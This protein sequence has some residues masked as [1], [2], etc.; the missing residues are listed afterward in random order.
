M[1]EQKRKAKSCHSRILGRAWKSQWDRKDE[2][3]GSNPSSESIMCS[4]NNKEDLKSVN[5]NSNTEYTKR[6]RESQVL[7]AVIGQVI[8]TFPRLFTVHHE[9]AKDSR[10]LKQI[11]NPHWN[12]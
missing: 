7:F 4:G 2:W 5:K 10:S 8:I 6:D 3:K 9:S 11:S 12:Q 1:K